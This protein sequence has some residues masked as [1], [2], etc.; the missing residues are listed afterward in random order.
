[1]YNSHEI[2]NSILTNVEMEKR[3]LSLSGKGLRNGGNTE[4]YNARDNCYTYVSLV[5]LL[6]YYINL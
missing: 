1:M 3:C 5:N 4:M 2:E 6:N